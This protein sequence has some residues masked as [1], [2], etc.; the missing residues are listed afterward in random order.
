[1]SVGLAILQQ[2]QRSDYLLFTGST[3]WAHSL[4]RERTP[5]FEGMSTGLPANAM[6]VWADGKTAQIR[7]EGRANFNS[8]VDFKAVINGLLEKGYTRFILDLTHCVLMDS[9]FLGVLAGLGMR[10]SNNR[11]GGPAVVIELLNANARIADLLDNLGV[12]HL[13]QMVSGP[14]L[15]NHRLQRL[16]HPPG[17]HDRKEISRTCL[18]AHE[19]LMR[20]NPDNVAKFKDVAQFLAEDLKKQE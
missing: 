18:E 4:R 17:M 5:A 1:L 10:F 15:D 2:G 19:T 20:I 3:W 7:I 13:F 14:E 8:S 6:S 11:N 16:E 12:E 9:T